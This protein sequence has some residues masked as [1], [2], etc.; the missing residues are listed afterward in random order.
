MK[1]IATNSC[2]AGL[3][4]IAFV[5]GNADAQSIRDAAEPHDR[6][7]SAVAKGDFDGDGA[8]DVAIS[9][10]YEEINGVR[11]AGAVNVIYGSD[12]RLG[13]GPR[14][15]LLTKLLDVLRPSDFFGAALAAGKF[16]LDDYDDL[17][18]GIPGAWDFFSEERNVGEVQVFYGSEDGLR[19][20]GS[21][22]GGAVQ[23]VTA[24]H[25]PAQHRP[26]ADARFGFALA[27]ADFGGYSLDWLAIGAP[28]CEVGSTPR[29]GAVFL[30]PPDIN[31][32][33]T[34]RYRILH[35]DVAGVVG[36]AEPR[37]K[38]GRALAAG[39]FNGDGDFDL[40]VG[41]PRETLVP[42]T[43]QYAG[44]LHVFYGSAGGLQITG[45]QLWF[46][47]P[48]KDLADRPEPRD[49]FGRALC[50]GDFDA[51]GVSDLAVGVPGESIVRFGENVASAGAVHVLYGTP[52]IDGV[53][54][55]FTGGLRS[56]RNRLLHQSTPGIG[57]I[58]EP[59]DRFGYALASGELNNA[60]GDELVVGVPD[61]AIGEVA[62][63][64]AAHILPGSSTGVRG[65]GSTLLY[66]SLD[67]ISGFVGRGHRFGASL[68][69]GH[70]DL[71]FPADLVTG[72]PGHTISG[73]ASAGAVSVNYNGLSRYSTEFWHQDQ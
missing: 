44:A 73:Q 48:R 3:A 31:E 58:P 13:L 50:S 24:L 65:A 57:G 20:A 14:N 17:A 64:G 30:L 72:I 36:L 5:A 60:A 41:V 21:G 59:Y 16:N 43:E 62:H 37:D 8:L 68:L 56:T 39:D 49:L 40:A 19:E 12:T 25:F 52:E 53:G 61:E 46:Q 42:R 9:A 10:P 54:P 26:G 11:G 34:E 70:F 1:K 33:D 2:F 32:L 63:A 29:A 45:S 4:G 27:A 22:V 51:D 47:G 6:F 18:V 66:Q 55:P 38:F 15:Q 28:W 35:Q 23:A 7:G 67:Y 69:I 71:I